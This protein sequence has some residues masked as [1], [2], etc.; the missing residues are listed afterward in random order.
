MQ[1]PFSD[2]QTL[3]FLT[4]PRMVHVFCEHLSPVDESACN[5]KPKSVR[6]TARYPFN[7]EHNDVANDRLFHGLI[8]TSSRNT[9]SSAV[10]SSSF[11]FSPRTAIRPRAFALLSESTPTRFRSKSNLHNSS[12][13]IGL[14][15]L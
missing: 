3:L 2:D 13:V 7:A 4:R 15:L 14:F 1:E 8:P 5:P 12:K 10:N 9:Q 6:Q 11:G